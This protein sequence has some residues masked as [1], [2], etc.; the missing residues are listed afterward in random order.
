MSLI[1]KILHAYSKCSHPSL[2]PLQIACSTVFRA[3]ARNPECSA[4]ECA[5]NGS[6]VDGKKGARTQPMESSSLENPREAN[7]VSSLPPRKNAAALHKRQNKQLLSSARNE[8]IRDNRNLRQ[9]TRV[10]SHA[11]SANLSS[12]IILL[13]NSISATSISV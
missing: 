13:G 1:K 2:N 3:Q 9:H 11:T 12:K 5:I 4:Q 6:A 10:L 8:I 7:G